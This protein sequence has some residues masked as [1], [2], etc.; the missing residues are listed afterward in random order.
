MKFYKSR[1]VSSAV[2]SFQNLRG[3]IHTIYYVCFSFY[4]LY[5]NSKLGGRGVSSTLPPPPPLLWIS[6]GLC[7]STHACHMKLRK[8][9]EGA[10]RSRKLISNFGAVDSWKNNIR[11]NIYL[12]LK[13]E[14]QIWFYWVQVTFLRN[15]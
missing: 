7:W 11:L 3:Q 8:W 1:S 14:N 12:I 2:G 5:Y 10:S 4:P 15:D 13:A 9:Q 6:S